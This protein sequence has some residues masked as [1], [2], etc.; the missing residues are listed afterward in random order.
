MI[1]GLCVAVQAHANATLIFDIPAQRADLALIAFAEQADR[2]LLFSFDETSNKTANRL[3][4]QYEVV[5]ALELLLAGTGLSISMGKGQLSVVENLESNR[6]TIVE[7]PKSVL[8]RIGAVIAGAMVASSAAAEAAQAADATADNTIERTIEEVIVTSTRRD[9]ALMDTPL[10]IAV[11]TAEN[12]ESKGIVN[13]QTLYQSIPGMAYRTNASTYNTI[14]IR[15]LTQP[16][17]GGPTVGVYID[18]VSVTDSNT[19]AGV[20]QIAGSIFDLQRVEVLKGPQ[21]TLYGESTIGGAIRY[22][23]NPPDPTAFD[24]GIKAEFE[25]MSNTDDPGY[26]VNAMVNVPL[27]D[28]LAFRLTGFYRERA[29]LLDIPAPRSEDDVDWQEEEGFRA[30]LAWFP[31]ERLTLGLSA[32]MTETDYGGPSVADFEAGYSNAL[33]TQPDFPNGGTSSVDVYSFNLEYE[34]DAVNVEFTSSRFELETQFGEQTI[35]RFGAALVGAANGLIGLFD[36]TLAGVNPVAATGAFGFL[37]REAERDIHELRVL[38]NWESKWQWAVGLYYKDDTAF[39]GGAVSAEEPAF[40]FALAPGFEAARPVVQFIDAIFAPLFPTST[41]KSTEKAV[42]GEVS[43]RFNDAWELLAGLRFTEAERET[44]IFAEDITDDFAS[45]K[46]S[47]TWRPRDQLMTYFTFSQGFRP[48]VINDNL[49]G[50]IAEL[51]AL[52]ATDA[53]A[54]DRA[55][56]FK[57]RLT[58][59]GDEVS[60]YEL[61]LKTTL[62]DGRARLTAAIYHLDWKDTLVFQPLSEFTG[63]AASIGQSYND[64]LDGGAVSQGAEFEIDVDITSQW[65]LSIA[66]D[67]NWKAESKGDAAGQFPGPDGEIVRAKKGN[68]LPAAP[69]NSWSVSTDYEFPVGS[70]TGNGRLDWYRISSA[71]NRITNEI[72]TPGY[73]QLDARLSLVSPDQNWRISFYGANLTDETV[74]YECNEGGCRLGRPLTVGVSFSYGL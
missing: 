57:S 38:S 31:T 56:F 12:I 42:F 5:E 44:D 11:V 64:N 21:G 1:V 70:W 30:K 45:P 74:I 63:L 37:R 10:S 49:P 61:G 27:M 48:G 13:F 62:W 8:A 22:I 60:S 35:P 54:G 3:S 16:G 53:N 73:D 41:I 67:N 4:G 58:V 26:R 17:E 68:R 47:L 15:G 19:G 59:D 66:H 69:E 20:S 6:E 51:E 23:A 65:G 71:F 72:K 34:F 46:I 40:W 55:E 33:L 52:A 28:T 24:F 43:Y 7:R 14:S 25:E 2:T 9:T 36:P 32:Q 39:N 50:V 29:G 18:N